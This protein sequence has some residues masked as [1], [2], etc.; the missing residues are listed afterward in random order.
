MRCR[1][2]CCSNRPRAAAESRPGPQACVSCFLLVRC[3]DPTGGRWYTHTREPPYVRRVA[4]RASVGPKK[5]LGRTRGTRTSGDYIERGSVNP[6]IPLGDQPPYDRG[7]TPPSFVSRVRGSPAAAARC[8]ASPTPR[9]GQTRE[10]CRRTLG[11]ASRQWPGGNATSS[12]TP[13]TPSPNRPPR[14]TT[15]S[16]RR[17]KFGHGRSDPLVVHAKMLRLE[18]LKVKADLDANSRTSPS[19]ARSAASTCTGSAVSGSS[20]GHW[21]HAGARAARR[22]HPSRGPAMTVP[23]RRC[24]SRPQR[25]RGCRWRRRPWPTTASTE[26]DRNAALS[27]VSLLL[28]RALH[29]SSLP[30]SLPRRANR[31]GYRAL[32]HS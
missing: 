12:S 3:A 9:T 22:S 32:Q 18:L 11:L 26:P 8:G 21:A 24:R 20:P 27:L 13:S 10:I 6:L 7:W 4:N 1:W 15:S 29:R 14:P 31:H 30:P 28:I 23:V 5:N 16:T 25:S 17:S 2:S 19:T